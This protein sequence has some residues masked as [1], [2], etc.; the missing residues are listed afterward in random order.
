[1]LVNNFLENLF[2]TPSN[3]AVLRVLNNRVIGITGRET[4]RLT[5]LTHRSALKSLTTLEE[6]GVVTRVTGG[7][8][9]LF[10]LN[11]E[12]Y[13]VRQ[14][15]KHIF[16]AENNFNPAV[17]SSIKKSL[18][19]LTESIIIYGSVA[20]KEESITS[21]YDLCIV[22]SKHLTEIKNAVSKL[23]DL[24]NEQFYIKLAPI[25]ISRTEFKKRAHKN[26]SPVIN[27]VK[28]GI[29]ISGKSIHELI[30]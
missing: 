20:R 7:R 2:S 26:L 29:K 11:R 13:I 28:E 16:E 15:I 6:L 17:I 8:D 1:M 30:K 22:F 12:K 4:A 3:I 21:D 23:R 14:V 18:S 5:G 25:Y 19:K 10:T 9:H 24:L 27:I